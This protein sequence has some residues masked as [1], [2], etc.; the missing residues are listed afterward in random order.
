MHN[1][2]KRQRTGSDDL[3]HLVICTD[4]IV[5]EESQQS[6]TAFEPLSPL[7]PLTPLSPHTPSPPEVYAYHGAGELSKFKL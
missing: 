6:R 5:D 2:K 7:S 1:S 4:P 3:T